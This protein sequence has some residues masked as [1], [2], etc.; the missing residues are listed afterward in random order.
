MCTTCS[1]HTIAVPLHAAQPA[2]QQVS[3]I[4]IIKP[5]YQSYSDV[6]SEPDELPGV[7]LSMA[8]PVN[9]VL[10]PATVLHATVAVDM[11]VLIHGEGY[12]GA[13]THTLILM[14]SSAFS[15]RIA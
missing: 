13:I 8:P 12:E 3:V 14:L 2:Q 11:E 10:I 1:L 4:V 5:V 9:T 6:I 15:Q 7:R